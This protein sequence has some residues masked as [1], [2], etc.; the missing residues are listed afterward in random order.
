MIIQAKFT[1]TKREQPESHKFGIFGK[2]EN[3]FHK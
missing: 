3:I 2:E 1:L